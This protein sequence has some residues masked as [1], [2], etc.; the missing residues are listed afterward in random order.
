MCAKNREYVSEPGLAVRTCVI[1]YSRNG[2]DQLYFDCTA[3]VYS[4]NILITAAHCIPGQEAIDKLNSGPD[5]PSPL[6]RAEELEPQL[7]CP[8]ADDAKFTVIGASPEFKHVMLDAHDVAII[9]ADRKLNIPDISLVRSKDEEDQLLR[10]A[11]CRVVGYGMDNNGSVAF[12]AIAPILRPRSQYVK[13]IGLG[14]VQIPPSGYIDR[15]FLP[16]KSAL[17]LQSGDS[18]GGLYCK[19]ESGN[20][21]LIGIASQTVAERV[22]AFSPIQENSNWILQIVA[23]EHGDS[24]QNDSQQKSDIDR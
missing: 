8:G 18:G 6:M 11:D 9:R 1:G 5:R 19:T 20:W 24:R 12:H 2:D 14:K 4:G 16:Q 13:V 3:N 10:N 17:A 7:Y 15:W 21:I 22:D 23:G